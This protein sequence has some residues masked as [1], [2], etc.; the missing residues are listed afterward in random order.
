MSAEPETLPTATTMADVAPEQ[1]PATSIVVEWENV[2]LAG[3]TRAERMLSELG[4]QL[5]AL[6]GRFVEPP[7]V[8]LLYDP[9]EVDPDDVERATGANLG[10][11]EDDPFTLELVA[12]PGHSYYRQKNRGAELVGGELLV[13]LDSD[14]IPEDGWLENL[15]APLADERVDVVAGHT[16][17]DAETL[18]QRAGKYFWF[19]PSREEGRRDGFMA[20]NVAF[21][22][23]LFLEFG[24]FPDHAAYRYQC[25]A[26]G[27]ALVAAGIGIY[28]QREARCSHPAPNGL[29]H[30]LVRGLMAGHDKGVRREGSLGAGLFAACWTYVATLFVM[31]RRIAR[32]G[33]LSRT[34][35][36]GPEVFLAAVVVGSIYYTLAFVGEALSLVNPGLVERLY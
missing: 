23:E 20:N 25:V 3:N 24:G 27:Q 26:L 15:L 29:R 32:R 6:D 5:R 7:E 14:V 13:F 9:D 34:P 11:T 31:L 35:E 4:R 12:S 1:L 30:F 33:R 19:F 18:Y 22:R 17:L 28:Q 2:V 21:R 8:M 10:P 36:E 16:Y